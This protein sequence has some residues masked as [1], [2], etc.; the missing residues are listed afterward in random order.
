MRDVSFYIDW[1]LVGLLFLC[2]F[3]WVVA[4]GLQWVGR[5]LKRLG[6]RLKRET[7]R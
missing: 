7:R 3:I 1:G 5:K 2:G 6:N 4:Y